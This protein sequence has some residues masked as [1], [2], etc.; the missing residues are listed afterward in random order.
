M[1]GFIIGK[2]DQQSQVFD[3]AGKRIPVTV[4]K[5]SPCYIVDI[6]NHK[7]GYSSITLGFGETK[8][9]KKTIKG[10]L[11]KAGIKA[12]LRLLREIRLKRFGDKLSF[13]E[14]EGKTVFSIGENKFKTGDAIDPQLLFKKGEKVQVSGRSKG[15]GFQGVVRRHKF[16]GGPKTHGQSD[17]HRAP[18]S[19]GQTT[20]PGRVYKGK[21]MAG[22]MGG[23]TITVTNLE[24]VEAGKDFLKLSGLIPGGKNTVVIVRNF[25]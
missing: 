3:D 2:K 19:I 9:L 25:N 12:P 1:A 22:R 16:A 11:D 17:R 24:V 20:T 10:Q 4:I 8:N 6:N 18:G 15:K 7:R 13:T 5:T 21:R 23:E 14:E